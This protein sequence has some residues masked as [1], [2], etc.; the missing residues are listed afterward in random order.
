MTRQ[1]NHVRDNVSERAAACSNWRSSAAIACFGGEA[2]AEAGDWRS[3]LLP[4]SMCPET[5]GIIAAKPPR[6]GA[7]STRP[8]RGPM[9]VWRNSRASHCARRVCVRGARQPQRCAI[10]AYRTR[11]MSGSSMTRTITNPCARAV[12]TGRPSPPSI[13]DTVARRARMAGQ[14]IRNTRLTSTKRDADCFQIGNNDCCRLVTGRGA[15][16]NLWAPRRR[17]QIGR[18]HV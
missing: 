11:A 6:H 4:G 1:T 17:G 9:P 18:A 2:R 13:A 10:T 7:S 15:G 8:E 16:S 14:S 3:R 12:M 5:N